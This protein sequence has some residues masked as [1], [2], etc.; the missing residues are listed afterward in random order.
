MADEPPSLGIRQTALRS[1]IERRIGCSFGFGVKDG[2]FFIEFVRGAGHVPTIAQP[3]SPLT[4]LQPDRSARNRLQPSAPPASRSI[5]RQPMSVRW[6]PP[7]QSIFFTA[8]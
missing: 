7:G 6:N 2:R 1:S 4:G 3:A 5:A 8:A